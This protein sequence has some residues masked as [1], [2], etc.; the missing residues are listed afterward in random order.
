MIDLKSIDKRRI[1]K[2]V[3]CGS[4]LAQFIPAS[5]ANV[6]IDKF[7]FE[8]HNKMTT[9]TDKKYSIQKVCRLLKTDRIGNIIS[10][11]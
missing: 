8:S 2:M 1:Y 11:E 5:V 3:S 10:I 7:E 4:K 6:I 9:T